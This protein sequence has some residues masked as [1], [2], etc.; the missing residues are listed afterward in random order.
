MTKKDEYYNQLLRLNLRYNDHDLDVKEIMEMLLTIYMNYQQ[1]YY[2]MICKV[3]HQLE[4]FNCISRFSKQNVAVPS[5][6]NLQIE[7]VK[8]KNIAQNKMGQ[9]CVPIIDSQKDEVFCLI[10]ILIPKNGVDLDTNATQQLKIVAETLI[11]KSD[12]KKR[13]AFRD[14]TMRKGIIEENEVTF[15][16]FFSDAFSLCAVVDP[17]TWEFLFLNNSWERTLG[18]SIE[19]LKSYSFVNWLHVDDINESLRI[20]QEVYEGKLVKSFI[21]RYRTKWGEFKYFEWDISRNTDNGFIYC[22]GRDITLQHE[23]HEKLFFQSNILRGVQD[24]VL[25]INLEGRVTYANQTVIDLT[26]FPKKYLLNRSFDLIFKEYNNGIHQPITLNKINNNDSLIEVQVLDKDEQKIWMEVKTTFLSDVYG[27]PIGHLCILKNIAHR[28]DYEETLMKRNEALSKANKELD[29]FVYRV[30]HDLR[31]PITSALGLIELSL[32]SDY[33]QVKEYLKLQQ[34]SLKK[35]DDFIHDILNYSRNNRMELK[36]SEIDIHELLQTTLDQYKFINEYQKVLI[37]IDVEANNP[38]YCDES[39]LLVIINNIISNA[40][41][42]TSRSYKPCINIKAV[43]EPSDLI[44]KI[45][46]NGIGIRKE[47]VEKIFDMFYRATDINYG[48]GLGLYIVQEAVK[49]LGGEIEVESEIDEGTTFTI[50]VPNLWSIF[51]NGLKKTKEI[52]LNS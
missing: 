40:F 16:P 46:D 47:H 3:D 20:Y 5:F 4:F 52:K 22:M 42:F 36:P 26:G 23:N 37:E 43:V 21:N 30:S 6:E 32:D 13:N 34:R 33:T 31:A 2:G 45:S 15:K 44:L 51:P 29:N 49:R 27:D 9:V 7:S 1:A 28:K 25:V 35:L 18:F 14:S 12:Q 48:S 10:C 41:K 50:T 11:H 8:S 19:E 38:L 17:G 39:R 24:S